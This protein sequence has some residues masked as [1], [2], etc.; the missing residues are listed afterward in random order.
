MFSSEIRGIFKN[1]YNEEHLGRTV[2]DHFKNKQKNRWSSV[3]LYV[4]KVHM[5]WNL[6]N[7]YTLGLAINAA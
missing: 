3:F 4:I 5:F 1:L 7:L 6:F 2:S